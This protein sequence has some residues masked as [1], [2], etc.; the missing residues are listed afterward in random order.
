MCKIF[1]ICIF[2]PLDSDEYLNKLLNNFIYF[3][4]CREI[5]FSPKIGM[6]LLYFHFLFFFSFFFFFFFFELHSLKYLVR[7]KKNLTSF[8]NLFVD[9]NSEE[10]ITVKENDTFGGWKRSNKHYWSGI[11]LDLA[12]RRVNLW[13]ITW[14]CTEFRIHLLCYHYLLLSIVRM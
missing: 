9:T 13:F 1:I 11:I 5:N 12:R 3:C 4:Y 10:A 6:S 7:M 2:H 8:L 14:L